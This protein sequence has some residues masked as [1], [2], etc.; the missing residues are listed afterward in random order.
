M[1]HSDKELSDFVD[2][3]LQRDADD[4][5]KADQARLDTWTADQIRPFLLDFLDAELQEI[6]QAR[7]SATTLARYEGEFRRFARWCREHG[8]MPSLPSPPEIVALYLIEQLDDGASYQS[9]R[10]A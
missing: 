6:W 9:I 3:A 2:R 8:E 4:E 10:I 5:R 7:P 1:D